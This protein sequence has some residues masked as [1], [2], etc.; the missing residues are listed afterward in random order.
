M[1]A[2][3]S[4]KELKD[5]FAYLAPNPHETVSRAHEMTG[6]L[7][8][9]L[10]VAASYLVGAVPFGYLIAQLRGV[11]IIHQ[12]SG[13]IGATNVGRVLG[14][15]FGFLVFVLDFAKGALPVAAAGWLSSRMQL[16]LPEDTLPVA[17]GLAAFLGHLFPIYLR[18]HGG[19]GVATSAGV[20]AVLLPGPAIGALLAWVLIVCLTRYVSLGSLMAAVVLCAVRILMTPQPF[21]ENAAALTLFCLVAG[22]LVFLRHHANI[23]R[24]LN[25]TENRIKDS[26][27]M[28]NSIKMV[29]LLAL[30][31]WF[32]TV[33]F[34]SLVVT[35]SIFSTFDILAST[36]PDQRPTW[37]AESYEKQQASQAAGLVLAPI[38]SWYFLIQ[39]ICAL[40]ASA[41]GLNWSRA[42]PE[43]PVHKIRFYVLAIALVAI[44]VAWPVAHRVDAL[45]LARFAA[46]PEIAGPAKES[47]AT[48]HLISLLLNFLTLVL[49]AVGMGLAAWLPNASSPSAEEK[50]LVPLE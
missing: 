34:F 21:S 7:A 1:I 32:G 11:D 15:P 23:R 38:F 13:N 17:A 40:F 50:P 4:W 18:F 12:G 25:G 46:D 5:G 39:G 43:V 16:G 37:L 29:H 22:G 42:E 47:F 6:L 30:G 26:P 31:L 45:R 14:K 24:L 20:V 35:L 2:S 8:L 3:T 41:T 49:V 44:I 48:W 28:F 36:P 9:A 19:K 10:S 27:N 33:V